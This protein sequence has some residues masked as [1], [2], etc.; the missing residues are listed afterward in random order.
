M[1]TAVVVAYKR[2][3]DE[4]E[5]NLRSFI[6]ILEPLSDRFRIIISESGSTAAEMPGI[7]HLDVGEFFSRCHNFNRGGEI[8]DHGDAI[9]FADSD[10]LVR[11]AQWNR[12]L[13][14]ITDHDFV[15]PFDRWRY[16][17]ADASAEYAD[18]RHW[19]RFVSRVQSESRLIRK[20]N[21][22][23]GIVGIRRSVLDT[24]GWWDERF[25]GHGREDLAMDKL[26]RRGPFRLHRVRGSG[27]HSYH[28]TPYQRDVPQNSRVYNRD[29]KRCN[30]ER[31]LRWKPNAKPPADAIDSEPITA[32]P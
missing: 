2:D 16:A 6:H 8:V 14:A 26:A 18:T 9:F 27:F 23:G 24:I 28:P 12:A 7:D 25:V 5:R 10:I 11:R 15:K 3:S 30:Y 29:Y 21:L 13:R 31:I 20:R 4:R 19:R 17:S 22:C 1:K 32:S